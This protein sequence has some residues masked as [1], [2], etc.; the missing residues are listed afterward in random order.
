MTI[1]IILIIFSAFMG[2]FYYP[3]PYF[4]SRH[5]YLQETLSKYERKIIILI[6]ITLSACITVGM[7]IV[8]VIFR[9]DEEKAGFFA[10]L[11]LLLNFFSSEQFI[12]RLYI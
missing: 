11:L 10:Q 5:S 8:T 2:V 7:I 6:S 12:C 1:P 4:S 9:A 3:Y